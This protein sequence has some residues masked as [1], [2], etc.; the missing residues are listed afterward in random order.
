MKPLIYF[1]VEHRDRE[2][3]TIKAV[4][5]RCEDYGANCRI[6][7]LTFHLNYLL[8]LPTPQLIVMPYCLS[9][10]LWPIPIF[11][12]LYGSQICIV[13]LSWE[14]YLFPVNKHYKK[15]RDIFAKEQLYYTAWDSLFE[16]FLVQSGV[17]PS[18][19]SVVGDP[20]IEQL[21]VPPEQE[22]EIHALVSG[23]APLDD[24]SSV[25]FFPTNHTWAFMS[26][27]EYQGRIRNGYNP[28][29]AACYREFSKKSLRRFLSFLAEYAAEP[30]R[31]C[32]LRPH[33]GI[34]PS[35]YRDMFESQNGPLPANILI[36]RQFTIKEWIS[37]SDIVISNWS[38]VA[39][40]AF[41]LGK[42]AFLYHPEPMPKIMTCDFFSVVPIIR[43]L[44]EL[45]AAI[46]V[47]N[48]N[49]PFSSSYSETCSQYLMTVAKAASLNSTQSASQPA[50]FWVWPIQVRLVHLR[51]LIRA[52]IAKMGWRHSQLN[53]DYFEFSSVR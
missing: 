43:N 40:H 23:S 34:Q 15:P 48:V 44:S 19:I 37:V 2:L 16:R 18:H 14:Q 38:T 46:T 11:H 12:A 52:W 30:T 1:F 51:H 17:T 25:T 7:S 50:S 28:Q 6:F 24:Y 22:A 36:T 5:K 41:L 4:V 13:N 49:P 33:P 31:L 9:K 47:K 29:D 21:R 39:Y 26:D 53:D 3:P 42:Q 10:E 20:N 35:Q 8:K 45:D 27:R 32:V